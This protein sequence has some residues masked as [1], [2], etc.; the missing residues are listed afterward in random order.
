MASGGD[1][2]NTKYSDGSDGGQDSKGNNGL[3]VGIGR[4]EAVGFSAGVLKSVS[5]RRNKGLVI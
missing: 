3:V 1:C 2:M 4:V 5:G